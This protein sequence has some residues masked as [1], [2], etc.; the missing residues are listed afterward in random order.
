[1]DSPAGAAGTVN[2]IV[3]SVR[4]RAMKMLFEVVVRG[5]A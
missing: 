4:F 5:W 1:M 3:R 2:A